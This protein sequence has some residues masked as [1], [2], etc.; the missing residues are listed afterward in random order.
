MLYAN[1]PFAVVVAVFGEGMVRGVSAVSQ[2]S[3]TTASYIFLSSFSWSSINQSI[4][5]S[6]LGVSISSPLQLQSMVQ[7]ANGS[8]TLKIIPSCYDQMI[9]S[10]VHVR[11]FFNYDPLNDSLIPCKEAGLPFRE[12]D[13]LQ[14]WG[15]GK[16]ERAQ[17]K[18]PFFSPSQRSMMLF[19]SALCI[20]CPCLPL[21]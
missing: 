21:F 5:Q 8:I 7:C 20:L 18:I 9:S 6:F 11:A 2:L 15:C 10:Q 12:G 14:V 16:G 1:Y 17:W 3:F 19:H 13:V 4:N